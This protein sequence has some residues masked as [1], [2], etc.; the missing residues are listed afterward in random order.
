ME[1]KE[2]EELFTQMNLM[3]RSR[4]INLADKHSK[5]ML[6]LIHREK[7]KYLEEGEVEDIEERY[8]REPPPVAPPKFNKQE[9]YENNMSVFEVVDEDAKQAAKDEYHTFT[10]LVRFL[11]GR[12]TS[13][14]EKSRVIFRFVC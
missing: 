4:I 2:R 13:D 5:Q 7:V 9:V 8:P 10:A 1:E 11:V 6:D 3:E 14:I 12:C